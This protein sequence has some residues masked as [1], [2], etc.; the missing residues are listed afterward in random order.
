MFNI[1]LINA[2]DI[3]LHF[4]ID[5]TYQLQNCLTYLHNWL[6]T[7][8]LLLNSTKIY[9]IN[10]YTDKI[11]TEPAFPKNFINDMPIKPSNSTKYLGVKFNNKLNFDQHVL[12]LKQITIYHLYNL[13][14]LRPYINKT[15]TLLTHSLIIYRLN[16]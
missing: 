15:A 2:D 5:S 3:E 6:T 12:S 14:I 8:Y 4:N 9:L 16:Y 11:N 1:Y 10:I 7:N 13:Y